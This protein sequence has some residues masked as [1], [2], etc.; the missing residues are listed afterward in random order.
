MSYADVFQATTQYARNSIQEI[1]TKR[2]PK[3][4]NLRDSRDYDDAISRFVAYLKWKHAS[5]VMQMLD[6]K[7]ILKKVDDFISRYD[8]STDHS[9][10]Q[11]NE[12]AAKWGL[13]PSKLVFENHP[14]AEIGIT[15]A[16]ELVLVWNKIAFI[17]K[18]VRTVVDYV[19]AK[20]SDSLA[21]LVGLN[22]HNM[23]CWSATNGSPIEFYKDPVPGA[24][25]AECFASLLNNQNYLGTP[26][27]MDW[28][29]TKN[30]ADRLVEPFIQGSWPADVWRTL[31]DKERSTE[32]HIP[33]V[34]WINPPFI[35]DVMAATVQFIIDI[36]RKY[37]NVIIR[38]CFPTWDDLI[39]PLF[40][41]SNSASDFTTYTQIRHS[42]TKLMR[43]GRERKAIAA[44]FYVGWFSNDPILGS[45]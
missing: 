11:L 8:Q 35:A 22:Y 28:V 5:G 16:G 12:E 23:R 20:H 1:A 27:K 33:V 14:A 44:S 40:G 37:P 2:I 17:L 42:S 38:T 4:K 18:A 32:S 26:I 30:P 7:V 10:A 19:R 34:L 3:F 45:K 41:V 9:N 25:N 36:R 15:A 6:N 39:Q 31:E 24:F 29:F 13:K 21:C 43:N